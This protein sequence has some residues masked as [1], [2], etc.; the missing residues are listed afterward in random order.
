MDYA[1]KLHGGANTAY[2]AC[3]SNPQS[4][5]LCGKPWRMAV[6]Q[7]RQMSRDGGQSLLK[8]MYNAD[9]I[10]TNKIVDGTNHVYT[11]NGTQIVSEAWG[12]FLLIYL[13]DEKGF[14]LYLRCWV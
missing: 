11:L 12:N 10:G 4:N 3:A 8:F 9:G 5:M 14:V 1:E 7:L 2:G 6:R 13:Y